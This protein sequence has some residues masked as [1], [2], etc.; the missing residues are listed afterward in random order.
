MS[1]KEILEQFGVQL[2]EDIKA[3]LQET[4]ADLDTFLVDED[5][6]ATGSLHQ[7]VDNSNLTIYGYKYLDVAERGRAETRNP[8]DG[9]L[10]RS[11]LR[12]NKKYNIK[13]YTNKKTGKPFSDEATAYFMSN[14]YH[15]VGTPLFRAGG[16]SGVLS[17][18]ITEERIGT[19]KATFGTKYLNDIKSQ[20]VNVFKQ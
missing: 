4:S 8:G 5:G 19:F 10:R 11:I 3:N 1:D 20:I 16:G 9:A 7:T 2:I 12:Y 15:K 18:V 14:K 6:Q 17:D 13:G